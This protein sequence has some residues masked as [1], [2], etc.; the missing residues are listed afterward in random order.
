[1][2]RK[3]SFL[4]VLLVTVGMGWMSGCS[5]HDAAEDVRNENLLSK[6][7]MTDE[8]AKEKQILSFINDCKLQRS[9]LPPTT[10][11]KLPLARTAWLLEASFNLAFAHPMVLAKERQFDTVCLSMP[12][13]GD[14]V[15]TVD[16]TA[17]ANRLLDSL[18]K[19]Y[20]KC[21]GPNKTILTITVSQTLN[22]AGNTFPITAVFE[23]GNKINPNDL[24]YL[25]NF[26]ST[27]YW[28]WGFG[29]GKCG[30][31]MGNS[32]GSDAAS[33]FM[34]NQDFFKPD[35]I[36]PPGMALYYTDFIT[37]VANPYDLP[38]VANAVPQ[39]NFFDFRLYLSNPDWPNHHD[40]LS[41][42]EM[43]FYFNNL[44]A[45]IWHDLF[46]IGSTQANCHFVSLF[47]ETAT[48]GLSEPPDLFNSNKHKIIVKYGK[49]HFITNYDYPLDAPLYQWI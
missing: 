40:C 36:V 2:K 6:S 43:N 18:S 29:Q 39:D 17:C 7:D 20:A 8:S 1:M 3:L 27:N 32:F 46:P 34:G 15:A 41:P 49:P 31:Y 37:R 33:V 11:Q 45:I 44:S 26:D 24:T 47:I 42:S 10:M 12:F 13:V 30:P 28:Y 48:V 38:N 4:F 23:A 22:V 25:Y 9:Q 14:S 19:F 35:V 5:K 16:A 21:G